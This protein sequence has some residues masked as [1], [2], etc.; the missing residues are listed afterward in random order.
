MRESTVPGGA[1]PTE[2]CLPTRKPWSSEVQSTTLS[3]AFAR[4]SLR[5]SCIGTPT[6]EPTL[7]P[8]DSLPPN[9]QFFY[10]LTA[11]LEK[12]SDTHRLPQALYDGLAGGPFDLGNFTIGLTSG[13]GTRL[14]YPLRF[15]Q[16]VAAAHRRSAACRYVL[17]TR[18][19]I[20]VTDAGTADRELQDLL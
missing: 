7:D 9:A 5:A 3:R 13:Q 16:G 8:I 19:P 12:T 15:V 17:S 10:R 14:A 1:N 11:A 4:Q 6:P 2:N 18:E 20:L